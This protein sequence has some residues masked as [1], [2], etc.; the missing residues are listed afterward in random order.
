MYFSFAR[1]KKAKTIELND[2]FLMRLDPAT[3]EVW[4]LP[5]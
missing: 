4:G 1:P 5:C 2:D 3:E